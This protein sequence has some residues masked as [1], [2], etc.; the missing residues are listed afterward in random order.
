MLGSGS[1]STGPSEDDVARRLAQSKAEDRDIVAHC[2]FPVYGLD[3]RWTGR[4]WLGGWGK[5]GDKIEYLVLAHGNVHD[6]AAPLVRVE[7]RTTTPEPD[8]DRNAAES[9]GKRF[10]TRSLVQHLWHETGVHLEA[11]PSTFKTTED[12]ASRWEKTSLQVDG[13]S[14]EFSTLQVEAQWVALGKVGDALLGL[15]ARNVEPAEIGLITIG[16]PME[17]LEDDETPR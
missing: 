17:Y 15:Q 3:G 14:T 6:S 1:R 9:K 12:P 4:R 7:T 16:N 13:E 11:I 10:M 2:P 8:E 5:S